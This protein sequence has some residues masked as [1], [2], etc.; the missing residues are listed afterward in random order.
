ML[1]AEMTTAVHKVRGLGPASA[2]DLANMGIHTI[3]DLLCLIPRG[4][5]DRKTPAPLPEAGNAND[6]TYWVNTV[7]EIISHEYFSVRGS[8]TLKIRI[9]DEQGSASLLCFG[10]NFLAQKLLPQS[11]HRICGSFSFRFD[12]LQAS[13]FDT[14]PADKPP[15][16]FNRILPIYPLS[17]QIQQKRLRNSMEQAYETYA[18]HIDDSLPA[19]I[20]GSTA[21]AIHDIHFPPSIE[22]AANAR[23]TLAAEELFILQLRIAQIRLEHSKQKR[24]PPDRPDNLMQSFINSLAYSLTG[25]QKNALHEIY[26]DL[27]ADI[28]MRRLLHGDVGCGK[29]L[30]AVC[31]A[32][33][34]IESGG[35][36]LLIAPTSLL[37]QQHFNTI[38]QLMQT[39]NP[40]PHV[41]H[42]SGSLTNEE[43]ESALTNIAS[44]TSSLICA[45]HAAFSEDVHYHK[46]EYV[47]FDEQ[48]RFGVE[49][50]ERT[51]EKARQS[52]SQADVLFMSATP[53]PR[54]LAMTSFGD[55]D[56]ST[57]E[58]MPASRQAVKTHLARL[59]NEQ[60]VFDWVRTEL[61]S[62]RQAYFVLPLIRENGRL[63]L[64]DAQQMA[65]RLQSEIFPEY[66]TALL[67]SNIPADEKSA[68]MQQFAAGDIRILAA[69]SVIEV[70]IDVPNASCMVIVH[71]ERFGLAS[72]HQLRGR[73]GRGPHQ[74]YCFLVYADDLTED[75]KQRILTLKEH[76]NGFL[77]AE[78]DL[79]LRGPGDLAGIRQAG[80]LQLRAARL[81][82]DDDILEKMRKAAF[83]LLQDDPNL[84][85][86]EKIQRLLRIQNNE[87]AA[88]CA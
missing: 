37:A 14:E 12:E 70:G 41:T 11:R 69:T 74:S 32:L 58:D 51:I 18:K 13:S 75:A 36:V 83:S 25:G 34:V 24:Q 71:A 72:L 64:Q 17:G 9:Q 42:L 46:L 44:G 1:L 47:I 57:I 81:P 19:H 4:Y 16:T 76:S 63:Q 26:A 52:G 38:S 33:P 21:T 28:P 67:H 40:K 49:Q 20:C 80:F 60:K 7:A 3:H 43:R 88:P 59:S 65:K 50:R 77:I 62:G 29:T 6:Q 55:I 73:I 85:Q 53:I 15:R 86:H 82:E 54:T 30:V 23:A 61:Q 66:R 5:E 35:Q 45:T 39:L 8:M 79:E 68:I 56:I 22:A 48:H 78:K 84:D 27:Q 10:R 87:G 2:G 31:S